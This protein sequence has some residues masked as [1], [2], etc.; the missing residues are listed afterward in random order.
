MLSL[1]N[2]GNMMDHFYQSLHPMSCLFPAANSLSGCDYTFHSCNNRLVIMNSKSVRN[3]EK[4]KQA[5]LAYQQQPFY[6]Q[7]SSDPS[8]FNPSPLQPLDMEKN[9]SAMDS[10]HVKSIALLDPR[11]SRRRTESILSQ[12]RS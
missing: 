9:N 2:K 12:R 4:T 8:A 11:H 7:E 6:W 5:F 1:R 10:M 3:E